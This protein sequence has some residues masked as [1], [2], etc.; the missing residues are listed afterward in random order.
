M[1]YTIYVG[2]IRKISSNED[3]LLSFLKLPKIIFR[4]KKILSHLNFI[5]I[6]SLKNKL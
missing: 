5:K 1:I 6:K 4:V 2:Q 3:N